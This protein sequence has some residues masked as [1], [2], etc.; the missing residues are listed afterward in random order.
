M[1]RAGEYFLVTGVTEEIFN[2]NSLETGDFAKND[3]DVDSPISH[4]EG[5][6]VLRVPNIKFF[7]S[8]PHAAISATFSTMMSFAIDPT[9]NDRCITPIGGA[10]QF[11]AMGMKSPDASWILRCLTDRCKSRFPSVVMEIEFSDSAAKEKLQSD[12]R[13]WVQA[14][15]DEVDAILAL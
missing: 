10:T 4:L 2:N 1:T 6:V 9:L 3:E 12:V 5:I 13:F 14:S 11:D 7:N 15:K 8:G